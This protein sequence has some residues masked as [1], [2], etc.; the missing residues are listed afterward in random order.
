M[1]SEVR[2]LRFKVQGSRLKRLCLV[3]PGIAARMRLRSIFQCGGVTQCIKRALKF[4]A[5]IL[6]PSTKSSG[7]CSIRTIQQNVATINRINQANSR[8]AVRS[9]GHEI[10]G[11][12]NVNSNQ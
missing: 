3:S 1:R 8:E 7:P 10:N 11:Q 9:M 4:V 12:R 6:Q 5:S 2:R